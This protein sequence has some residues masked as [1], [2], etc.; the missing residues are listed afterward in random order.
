MWWTYA[1]HSVNLWGVNS[2]AG[3]PSLRALSLVYVAAVVFLIALATIDPNHPKRG[4]FVMALALRIPGLVPALPFLY[5][6]VAGCGVSR[7]LTPAV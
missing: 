4:L 7:T 3:T 6:A 5:V 2:R 1:L